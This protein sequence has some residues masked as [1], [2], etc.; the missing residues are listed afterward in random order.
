MD[1]LF[2]GKTEFK[3]Y[4][5]GINSQH[6]HAEVI[7][8]DRSISSICPVYQLESRIEQTLLEPGN[9]RLAFNTI[10]SSAFQLIGEIELHEI[11]KKMIKLKSGYM[12]SYKHLIIYTGSELPGEFV[13]SLLTLKHALLMASINIK[14]KIPSQKETTYDHQESLPKMDHL[15][16]FSTFL[17]QS[18]AIEKV[19]YPK[20]P[21]GIYATFTIDT[22]LSTKFLCH[23]KL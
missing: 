3:D 8:I 20:M 14:E 23:V 11:E 12:I 16:L 13:H 2:V 5:K 22:T 15:H 21:S 18:S 6:F 7:L 10:D 4:Q 17:E 19:I 1:C 9:H